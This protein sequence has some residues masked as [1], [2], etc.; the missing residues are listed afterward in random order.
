ME[1][2]RQAY[3][4]LWLPASPAPLATLRIVTGLV[5]LLGS[6]RFWAKGWIET[7]LLAAQ[8][9]FKYSG[10]EWVQMPPAPWMLYAVFALMVLSALGVMLGYRYRLSA[11]L[12]WGSFT[13]VELLDLTWYL[14]HYYFISLLLLLLAMLPAHRHLSLDVKFGRVQALASVPGWMV[15]L[16]RWQMGIL[17]VY[18]GLAKIQSDWL[19]EALP[20][21]LWLPAHNHEPVLGPLFGWTYTPWLFSWAGMLYDCTIPFWLSW[22]KSRPWAYLTVIVFHALTGWLF[23][24]GMFPV[25]MM[26]ITLVFFDAASHEKWQKRFFGIWA[27]P[28]GTDWQVGKPWVWFTAAYLAFQLL[29]PWR[30]VLYPGQLFWTEAGY[31]FG[32]RVMLMEKAGTATFY[33]TRADNGREGEVDNADFLLPHQEKQMAMQPDLM[34]QYAHLLADHYQKQGIAV[35]KVRAEVYVTLQGKPSELYF[36]PQL[37]LLTLNHRDFP[38]W[39]YPAP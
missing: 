3:R 26:A 25:V 33:V 17:Y 39:L 4:S 12:L 32:W 13:Y 2:L 15:A 18:A 37:N 1:V 20:M 23:Q 14:N 9:Q 34:V 36:D 27:L 21:R 5:M 16:P 30:F 11:W 22:K 38:A 10:F 24:I 35:A 31:R 28:R 29:F 7:N 19:I 6:L 8:M